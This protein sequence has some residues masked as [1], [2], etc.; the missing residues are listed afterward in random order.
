MNAFKA[1]Q[2]RWTKGGAQT[3]VKLLPTVLS[4]KSPLRVK[5]EAFFHLSSCVVYILM[6]LLSLLIGPAMIAKMLLNEEYTTWQMV[7]DGL[8]FF[9]GTGSALAFYIVSQRELKRRGVDLFRQIPAL[10]AIGIGIAFNNAVAAIEG[11]FSQAGEFVRTPKFGDQA[12]RNGAW[13]G[14][15]SGFR[16]RG[17]WKAWAELGLALYMTACLCVFFFFDD[18]PQRIA[19]ALPFLGLFIFGYFYVAIQTFYGQWLSQRRTA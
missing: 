15:L 6:V 14:R 3:C 9:V 13:Q 5:F 1:Q 2:H 19:A 18:W 12:R 4:S 10:M 7:F 16:F 8:L 11:F 17:A